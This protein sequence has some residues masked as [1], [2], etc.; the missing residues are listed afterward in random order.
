MGS[1][2]R[3]T[4]AHRNNPDGTTDSICRQCFTTVFTSIWEAELERAERDHVCDPAT[5]HQWR[6]YKYKTEPSRAKDSDS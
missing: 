1:S 5:L 6:Q 4:F 3:L 2:S